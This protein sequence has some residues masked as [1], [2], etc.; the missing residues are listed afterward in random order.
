M[1]IHYQYALI[2]DSFSQAVGTA[3]KT[4]SNEIDPDALPSPPNTEESTT[5]VTLDKGS[6]TIAMEDVGTVNT[7]EPTITELT[8][9]TELTATTAPVY[10]S[11]VYNEP[12][13][14]QPISTIPLTKATDPKTT[15]N[16][17]SDEGVTTASID[18]EGEI[19]VDE[20]IFG[21]GGGGGIGG[22]GGMPSEGE[23][24]A[25][26]PIQKTMMPLLAVAAGAAIL[27]LKPFK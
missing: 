4:M 18:E 11:P 19:S 8:A 27:I 6:P 5:V 16:I 24:S 20:A 21:G 7:T 17:Y 9:S 26:M 15:I 25:P 2:E 22:G 10:E 14:E 3:P 1:N 12:L 13:P 23:G